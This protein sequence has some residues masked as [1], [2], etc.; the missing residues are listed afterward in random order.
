MGRA[1]LEALVRV[2]EAQLA[3]ENHALGTWAI[4][5]DRERRAFVF[6]KCE[7]GGY[8]EERPSVIGLDGT[9]LDKGGPI[10]AGA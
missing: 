4:Q 3:G 7:H 1:E 6:D 2:L 9:V 10:F 5:Y 8:C